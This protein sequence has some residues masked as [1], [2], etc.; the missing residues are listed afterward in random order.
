MRQILIGLILGAVV[1]LAVGPRI[2]CIGFIGT[3]FLRLLR[4][5]VVPLILCNIILAVAGM[6][7]VK[8]LGRIG[9]KLIVIFLGTTILAATV[10]LGD[11]AGH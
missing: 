7:D 4:C 8:K 9:I 11:R 5:C 2:S 6:G 1:G 10:G 3:I